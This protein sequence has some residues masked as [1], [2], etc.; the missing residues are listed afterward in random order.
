M[1][2]IFFCQEMDIES[3]TK[4]FISLLTQIYKDLGFNEFHIQ[5]SDRPKTRAGSDEIWDRAESALFSATKAAKCEFKMNPGDGAFYGPKLEFVLTDALGRNWQ[6]GTLQVDFVLPERLD[7]N[8]INE[9]GEKKRPVILH[10][11]ILGSFERFIGI[12]IEEFSG[13]I[14]IWLSPT[15][16]VV[17][18]IVSDANNFA[19]SLVKKLSLKGIRANL[20]IINEKINYK[21]REHSHFKI[22]YILAVGSREILDNS[23]TVRKIGSRVTFQTKIEDFLETI[24]REVLPPDIIRNKE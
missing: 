6:C 14:P 20:D 1:T 17:A 5:F 13:K 12:M 11:A 24:S 19:E 15:Q 2:H 23:V 3:E 18:S 10:R 7:A 9:K 8:Y 22:P 4:S 16:V 21:I